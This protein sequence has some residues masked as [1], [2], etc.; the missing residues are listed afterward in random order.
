MENKV[1]K[2]KWPALLV[3]LI[4]LLVLAGLIMFLTPAPSGIVNNSNLN[5]ANTNVNEPP[6]NQPPEIIPGVKSLLYSDEKLG[7]QF[8]FPENAVTDYPQAANYLH[9]TKKL[10]AAAALPE[11]M[12]AGTNLGEAVFAVG[13]DSDP[14]VV[15]DCLKLNQIENQG[16][17]PVTINGVSF[18]VFSGADPAAGNLYES[19]VYRA[20]YHG[21]CYE[22]VELLHSGNI[23]NYTLGA[24]SEFDKVKFSGI[25]EKM[26]QSLT[27]TDNLASGVDGAVTLG[28][29]CPVEKNPPEPKCAPQ[30]YHIR[31]QITKT[32]DP[33]F[34]QEIT[35]G[36][37]GKIG[38]GL[39]PGT[40][41]FSPVSGGVLPRCAPVTAVV[42]PSAWTTIVITC[43]TGIR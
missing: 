24:V 30:P 10:A 42:K 34:A 43:D 1:N 37:D 19:K 13:V 39:E 9:L 20:V 5:L 18:E 28:P 3:W 21:F 27:L 40:Y 35:S 25:L 32:G 2:L 11:S 33:A 6:V 26:A 15:S 22:A 29:I 16:L 36:A 31:I 12:F 7:F 41:E 4:I 14:A 23:G 38:V 8:W 17:G